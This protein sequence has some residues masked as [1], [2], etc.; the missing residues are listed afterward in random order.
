MGCQQAYHITPRRFGLLLDQQ[1]SHRGCGGVVVY[2]PEFPP[3]DVDLVDDAAVLVFEV[4][5][6]HVDFG[7]ERVVPDL[8]PDPFQRVFPVRALLRV[9]RIVRQ[10]ED[11]VADPRGL[12]EDVATT[13]SG[14]GSIPMRYRQ[15]LGARSLD[16]LPIC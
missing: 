14:M 15:P 12:A 11:R 7:K 3:G 1:Q 13:S 6:R 5:F 8:P 10:L 16:S 2:V 9:R 4:Q